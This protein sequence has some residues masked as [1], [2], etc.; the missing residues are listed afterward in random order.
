MKTTKWCH[1]LFLVMIYRIL[2]TGG[3]GGGKSTMCD[4][5]NEDFKTVGIRS[6]LVNETA[7]EVIK[8]CG[9]AQNIKRYFQDGVLSQFQ[10][11]STILRLQQQKEVMY[12]RMASLM[13]FNDVFQN[14]NSTSSIQQSPIVML[15]D[16]GICDSMAF[17][18]DEFEWDLILK[19]TDCNIDFKFSFREH[20]L[21]AFD[22][23][24]F[25]QTCAKTTPSVYE[26]TMA[27]N[28]NQQRLH[29]LTQ[30]CDTDQKLYE[31]YKNH[32]NVHFIKTRENFDEKVEEVKQI[33]L[34][35]V[36]ASHE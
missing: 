3:P 9:G 20:S 11:Q 7:H 13:E 1:M 31:I 34:Q 17:L 10:F 26:S 2:F 32:K 35:S 30:A 28:S 16:R 21:P 14:N 23:V 29:N 15:F 24:F 27:L 8:S 5:I 36:F 12:E 18:E 33:I 25:I 6:V 19:H 4:L 22:L